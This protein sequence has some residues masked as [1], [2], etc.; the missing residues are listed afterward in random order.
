[1]SSQVSFDDDE[2]DDEADEDADDEDDEDGDGDEGMG[3]L[4]SGDGTVNGDSWCG[5]GR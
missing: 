2:G 3:E 1:M 5:S 4:L